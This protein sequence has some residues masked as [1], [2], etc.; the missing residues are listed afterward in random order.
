[1]KILLTAFEPF[2]G[3]QINAAHE[4]VTRLS[5]PKD[6]EL[7]KLTV[8]T[9]FGLCTDTVV[10]AMRINLPDAVV[11]VGQAAGRAAITPERIAV[12][13]RDARIPDNA[14]FQPADEPIIPSGPAA[15]FSTL[16]VR[17]IVDAIQKAG[18][19]AEIS[20][21]AGLFVCNDLF[22]GILHAIESEFPT[23]RGGFIH[24]PCTPE[25][26]ASYFSPVPSMKLSD[27]VRGL[28]TVLKALI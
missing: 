28:E 17:A 13:L 18:I 26:A 7:C 15:Y 27:T 23:V 1:M 22:Y 14:G 16:P 2:G 6:I 9:V 12:N 20:N 8:P 24:V 4:A 3:E 25:Q 11:C 5:A 21:S 10:R 19:P